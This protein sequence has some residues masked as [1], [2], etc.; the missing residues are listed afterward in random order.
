MTPLAQ[1]LSRFGVVVDCAVEHKNGVAA[2]ARHRPATVKIDD[3]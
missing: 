3:P 1:F 2:V